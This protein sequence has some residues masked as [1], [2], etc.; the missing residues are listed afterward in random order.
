MQGTTKIK[1]RGIW[2]KLV[3]SDMTTNNLFSLN[4]DDNKQNWFKK[5]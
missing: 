5:I 3:C 2:V 4:D 1:D